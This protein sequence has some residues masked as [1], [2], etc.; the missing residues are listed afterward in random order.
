[1]LKQLTIDYMDA[2]AAVHRTSFDQALPT[3]AGLHTP[4]EDSWF[5]REMMFTTCQL[6]G[7]FANQDIVGVIA[8]REGWIDQLYIL[9][10]WQGRRTGAALLSVAQ[11]QFDHLSLSTFQRNRNARRFYERH[12][13]VL[14]E[15]TDG[16]RNEEK[17]PDA[18]YSWQAAQIGQ[19]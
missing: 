18:L 19:K 1:M 11:R 8:F 6:W 16:S 3:F 17:E 9:P 12:G 4:A 7:S 15:E 13:F 5:Y 10:Q 14:A 2:A